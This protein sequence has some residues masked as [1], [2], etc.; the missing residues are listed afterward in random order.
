MAEENNKMENQNETALKQPKKKKAN[1]FV[2][3]GRSIAKWFREL[4]SEA[5]KVVWPTRKQLINNTIIVIVCILFVG[6]FVWVLDAA[7]AFVRNWLV[8]IF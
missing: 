8:S 1:I 2:R 4:H 6:V 3:M 5:K 7:F